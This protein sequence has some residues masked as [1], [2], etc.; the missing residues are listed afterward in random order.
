[1]NIYIYRDYGTSF[2]C[3]DNVKFA[4]SMALQDWSFNVRFITADD[5]QNGALSNVDKVSLF[6]MGGGRFTEARRTLGPRGMQAI[7]D[8]IESGGGY[9]GICMGAYAAFS[10]IEFEGKETRLGKGLSLF[11]SVVR[12]HLN[13]TPSFDGS[14][15]SATII[16]VHHIGYEINSPAL[17]WGGFDLPDTQAKELNATPVTSIITPDGNQKVLSLK[18]DRG[19]QGRPIYLSATHFE[20][21]TRKIIWDTLKNQARTRS[22]L[23]RIQEELTLY[24]ANAYYMGLASALDNMA[25]VKGHSFQKQI[26]PELSDHADIPKLPDTKHYPAWVPGPGK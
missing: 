24:P 14:A 20:A 22:S 13:I 11:N 26:W 21:F 5:I 4:M 7:Q 25:L 18:K 12:G 2:T 16:D 3:T 19:D 8:Y 17:Y 15:E 6:V 1:M 10:N 23:R 9:C